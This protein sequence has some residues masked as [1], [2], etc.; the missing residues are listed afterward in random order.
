MLSESHPADPPSRSNCEGRLVLHET[1][2]GREDVAMTEYRDLP[3]RILRLDDHG[4]E[5]Q[6]SRHD[7]VATPEGSGTKKVG[8]TQGKRSGTLRPSVSEAEAGAESTQT[9][10]RKRPRLQR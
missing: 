8:P 7:A 1:S 9:L 6:R 10:Y 5:S 4:S 3:H 2:D